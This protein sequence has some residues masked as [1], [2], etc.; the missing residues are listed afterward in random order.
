M[1]RS[2]I[3]FIVNRAYQF[4]HQPTS[5]HW[6]AMKCIMH[7]LHGTQTHGLTLTATPSLHLSAFTDTDWAS[8]LDDRH[9]TGN[10]CVFL[11]DSLVSWSSVKQRVVSR[12]STESEYHALANLAAELDW[13]K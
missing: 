3:V 4:M 6:L 7:Y 9:S 11:G 13:F 5:S 8:S 12:S 1:T 2:N 10:F